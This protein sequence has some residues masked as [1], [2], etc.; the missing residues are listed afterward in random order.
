MLFT[1]FGRKRAFWIAALIAI[2]CGARAATLSGSVP[3]DEEATMEDTFE[4]RH[5][6]V[7]INRPSKDVYDFISNG[8]NFVRWASGLGDRFQRAGD[9]WVARGPL[10]TVRVRVVKENE[11]GVADHDVVLATGVTVRN[12]IRVIPNGTGSTVTFTL[13]RMVGVSDE[14]FDSD[15]KAVEKDLLTLKALLE[16]R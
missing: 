2:T 8:D 12:P 3:T 10:G 16:K 4:F 9:E 1:T 14:K 15:A 13:I 7:S 5:V 11:F 6:S